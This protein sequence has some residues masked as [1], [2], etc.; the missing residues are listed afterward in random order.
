MSA[1][2]LAA[3]PHLCNS[4][5]DRLSHL[6]LLSIQH[7]YL[8][9]CPKTAVFVNQLRALVGLSYAI[10]HMVEMS[11]K[12]QKGYQKY[13]CRFIQHSQG[14]FQQHWG[15]LLLLAQAL[16]KLVIFAVESFQ[17]SNYPSLYHSFMQ[18]LGKT[19]NNA[20]IVGTEKIDEVQQLLRALQQ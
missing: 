10:C 11:E 19:L 14:D 12:D 9:R 16:A 4:V 6:F 1:D 17:Q 8:Q 20:S 13:F 5:Y 18:V 15:A 7:F 2:S 3:A